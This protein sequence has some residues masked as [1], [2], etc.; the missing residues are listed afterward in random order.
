[1]GGYWTDVVGHIVLEV[2][3]ESIEDVDKPYKNFK[4]FMARS[5]FKEVKWDGFSTLTVKSGELTVWKQELQKIAEYLKENNITPSGK[6]LWFCN[7]TDEYGAC[8][9]RISDDND[10]TVTDSSL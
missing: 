8:R 9:I 3:G 5:E 2:D 1:M 4:K 7:E 10:Y 6:M